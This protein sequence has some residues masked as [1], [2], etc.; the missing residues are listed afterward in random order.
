MSG[1]TYHKAL[2]KT[3]IPMMGTVPVLLGNME[4]DGSMAHYFRQGMSLFSADKFNFVAYGAEAPQ[5]D[6]TKVEI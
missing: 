1:L 3:A 6:L 2:V 5:D 4:N